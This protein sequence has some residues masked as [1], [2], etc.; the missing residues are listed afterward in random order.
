MS[1][2]DPFLWLEEIESEAA[3]AWVARQNAHTLAALENAE[4]MPNGLLVDYHLDQGNGIEAVKALREKLGADLPAILITADRSVRV[5][6]EARAANIQ[7]LQKPLKP[8]ALR[9]M[10]SQWRVLRAAAAE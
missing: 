2:D 5:R 6:A 8:A 7:V 10:L 1:D 9:A 3:L 4:V